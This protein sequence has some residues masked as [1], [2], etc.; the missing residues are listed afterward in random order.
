[1]RRTVVR[2]VD[3]DE[4]VV[5]D[6]VADVDDVGAAPIG[7]DVVLDRDPGRLRIAFHSGSRTPPD[8]LGP[9]DRLAFRSLRPLE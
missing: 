3:V 1:V 4:E 6:D 9:W 8:R 7:E 2:V 5:V